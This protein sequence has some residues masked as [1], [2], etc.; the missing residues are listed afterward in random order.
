MDSKES[1]EIG[2]K[3]MERGVKIVSDNKKCLEYT[4][5]LLYMGVSQ[6]FSIVRVCASSPINPGRLSNQFRTGANRCTPTL[7]R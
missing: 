7:S 1:E 6:P 4:T 3:W 2:L 5:D